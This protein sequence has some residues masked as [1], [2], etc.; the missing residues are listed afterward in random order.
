MTL[1]FLGD[2]GEDM[3]VPLGE[4]LR[5]A[6]AGIPSF[7][8]EE[9]RLG[10][11]PSLKRARVL[12]AGF[13]GEGEGLTRLVRA[14]FTASDRFAA[15]DEMREFVPHLTVARIAATG[16]FDPAP[17]ERA[18]ETIALPRIVW[19]VRTVN[20]MRSILKAQGAEHVRLNEFSL[21]DGVADEALN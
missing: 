11:F 6:C 12:W 19:P 1:R 4:A 20:L 17:L 5:K 2:V 3:I 13:R 15:R 14:V 8:L 7:V 10:C 21:A 16:G 9:G 18:L